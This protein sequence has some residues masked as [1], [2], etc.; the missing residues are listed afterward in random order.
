ML[1]CASTGT[2]DWSILCCSRCTPWRDRSGPETKQS[3]YLRILS[4]EH[5]W[6][7]RRPERNTR[8]HTVL[9]RQATPVLSSEICRLGEF[10]LVLKPCYER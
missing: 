9:C 3:G 7:S 6:G 4:W 8:F 10:A 1:F 5:L 2:L